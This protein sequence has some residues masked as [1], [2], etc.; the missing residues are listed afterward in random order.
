MYKVPKA[1]KEL[2]KEQLCKR[3]IHL[4]LLRLYL[5]SD[6]YSEM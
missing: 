1:G 5:Q 2:V 6:R 4:N 3:F